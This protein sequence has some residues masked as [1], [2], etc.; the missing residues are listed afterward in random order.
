MSDVKQIRDRIDER[1][2]HE[3]DWTVPFLFD[4]IRE[5]FPNADE[6][7][8]DEVYYEELKKKIDTLPLETL[9]QIMAEQ[10]TGTSSNQN[11]V[12]QNIIE[13]KLGKGGSPSREE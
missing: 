5:D 4:D 12:L 8:F 6:E 2:A 3:A 1:L 13:E 9:E 7:E 10:A 11:F